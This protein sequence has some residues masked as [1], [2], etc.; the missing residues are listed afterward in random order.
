MGKNASNQSFTSFHFEIKLQLI[1]Y[2]G[3]WSSLPHDASI[4]LMRKESFTISLSKPCCSLKGT[5]EFYK[6]YLIKRDVWKVQ[7][8]LFRSILELLLPRNESTNS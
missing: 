2:A 8:P 7:T 1:F 3:K 4:R 6:N 5:E